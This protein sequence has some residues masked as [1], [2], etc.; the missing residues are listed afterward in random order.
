YG[1]GI[2]LFLGIPMLIALNIPIVMYGN[3]IK[4]YWIT[5]GVL[6]G[7]MLLLWIVWRAVGFIK[8]KK[9]TI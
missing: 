1:S 4:G 2:S 7:Y 5:L 6:I 3:A 9:P 8:F